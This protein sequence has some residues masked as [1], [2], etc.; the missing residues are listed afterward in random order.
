MKNHKRLIEIIILAVL[1]LVLAG[2][3]FG[4]RIFAESIHAENLIFST[5]E[6]SQRITEELMDGHDSF[7]TY[8][9]GMTNEQL[10]A[11]NRNLDGFFGHVDSYTV[12]R[13][14]NDHVMQ[15]YFNLEVSD[16]YYAY[17]SIVHGETITN[18]VNAQVLAEK[19]KQIMQSCK[20]DSDYQTVV[21]YHDYIVSHTK[22]GFLSGEEEKLSYTAYGALLRETAVCNGYA[23]AMELLL[24]CSDIDTY[25]AVGFTPDGAHAWN[26]VLIDGEWYHVD[27]TWDDPVDADSGNESGNGTH[28]YLNVNDEVMK[29]T[30]TWN[31]SAY[32][33]CVSMVD[34]YYIREHISFSTVQ[35]LSTYISTRYPAVTEYEVQ[36]T[37]HALSQSD[38]KLIM[39][40]IHSASGTY[41]M[42]ESGEYSVY[43]IQFE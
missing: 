10:V 8:V 3:Y 9:S 31:Q 11:I 15:V 36:L 14:V 21:N 24:L 25:M 30:H 19:V 34:N 43:R 6:L 17:Q 20:T 7:M 40:E 29:K 18:N 35:E 26:I 4:E 27:T 28:V 22:Y 12:I 42:Y 38:I 32:P 1:L 13:K 2:G 16:N 33:E 5:E 37:N 41:I 39:Q 23:E